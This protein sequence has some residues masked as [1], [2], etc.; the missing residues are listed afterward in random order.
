MHIG[1]GPDAYSHDHLGTITVS[2]HVVAFKAVFCPARKHALESFL[3]LNAN[4][5]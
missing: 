2:K 4:D 3:T 5:L 1:G